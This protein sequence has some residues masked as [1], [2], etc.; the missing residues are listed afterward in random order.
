MIFFDFFFKY[1]FVYNFFERVTNHVWDITA[2]LMDPGA[3]S[4]AHVFHKVPLWE[5]K[6]KKRIK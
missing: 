4:F 2:P 1:N 5:K 6:E 3:K